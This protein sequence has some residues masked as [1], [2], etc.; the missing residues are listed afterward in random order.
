[1]QSLSDNQAGCKA[2]HNW[3]AVCVRTSQV[4]HVVCAPVVALNIA[5]HAYAEKRTP[6]YIIYEHLNNEKYTPSHAI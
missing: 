5:L 2:S 3:H 6:I 1:M 4:A